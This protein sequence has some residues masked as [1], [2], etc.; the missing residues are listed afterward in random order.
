MASR[1]DG[2]CH[3]TPLIGRCP[4]PRAHNLVRR[5]LFGQQPNP[6]RTSPVRSLAALT[7]PKTA[8]GSFSV[9]WTDRDPAG[10]CVQQR[11]AQPPSARRGRHHPRMP[12][13]RLRSRQRLARHLARV[14]QFHHIQP[15]TGQA[16]ERPV[17]ARAQATANRAGWYGPCRRP[18]HEALAVRRGAR[19]G[20]CQNQTSPTGAATSTSR[21]ITGIALADAE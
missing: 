13:G 18:Q 4:R 6:R 7:F 3:G 8:T 21:R 5:L 1:V 11:E 16:P 12:F 17:G 10:H 2:A 14:W 9:V 19:S 15:S 20:L